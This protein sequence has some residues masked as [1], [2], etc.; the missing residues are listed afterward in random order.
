M[1]PFET[2][3]SDIHNIIYSPDLY[4]ATKEN[5]EQYAKWFMT[6]YHYGYVYDI[7]KDIHKHAAKITNNNVIWED[8]KEV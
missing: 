6:S 8:Q 4:L 5:V 2:S 1:N 7:E 3:D